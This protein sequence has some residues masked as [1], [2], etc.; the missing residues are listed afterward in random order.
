MASPTTIG[1]Q[2][3]GE[4]FHVARYDLLK[5]EDAKMEGLALVKRAATLT[6]A[7]FFDVAFAASDRPPQTMTVMDMGAGQGGAAR[8]IADKYG[9]KTSL[10][11]LLLSY[12]C[13]AQ[14]HQE[15]FDA[16]PHLAF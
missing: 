2:V 10:R 16:G 12:W 11:I 15:V 6:T 13:C 1:L 4:T 7:F 8:E 14:T 9:C 5:R 3:W